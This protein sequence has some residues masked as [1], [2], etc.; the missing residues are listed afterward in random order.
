L[1]SLSPEVALANMIKFPLL[2]PKK[3]YAFLAMNLSENPALAPQ[4][5]GTGTEQT[6][7]IFSI[8]VYKHKLQNTGT[9]RSDANF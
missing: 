5:T 6:K 4:I 7:Q 8:L 2:P 1:F 9:V 3:F